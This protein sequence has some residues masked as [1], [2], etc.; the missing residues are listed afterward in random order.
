MGN[1]L[2]AGEIVVAT[3]P[4]LEQLPHDALCLIVHAVAE[5]L[6][7]VSAAALCS[8]SRELRAALRSIGVEATAQDQQPRK[9]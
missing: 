3:P 9:G 4:T 8:T 2:T 6:V 5:P 1:N 7:P